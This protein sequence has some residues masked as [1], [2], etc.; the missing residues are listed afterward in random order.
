MNDRWI[1]ISAFVAGL[2]IGALGLHLMGYRPERTPAPTRPVPTASP[3]AN[4]DRAFE[5]AFPG[6]RMGSPAQQQMA[7]QA[8]SQWRELS[9]LYEQANREIDQYISGNAPVQTTPSGGSLGTALPPPPPPT[10]SP[11]PSAPTHVGTATSSAPSRAP[12][13][14]YPPFS[15]DWKSQGR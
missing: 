7:N 11:A 2:T 8:V 13:I 6:L 10:G 12:L 5:N 3:V 9:N 4:G 15:L 14:A 1:P